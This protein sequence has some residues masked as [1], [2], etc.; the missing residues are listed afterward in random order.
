MLTN[1]QA[2]H[3]GVW[4]VSEQDNKF[5]GIHV[6]KVKKSKTRFGPSPDTEEVRSL[7]I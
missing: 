2:G 1:V 7:H 5:F 3:S 6:Y 4:T